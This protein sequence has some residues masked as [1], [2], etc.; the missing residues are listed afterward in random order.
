MAVVAN[1]PSQSPKDEKSMEFQ[2]LRKGLI[3][4]T[5]RVTS[6][7]GAAGVGSVFGMV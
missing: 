4:K 5:P 1:K 7:A 3:A 6:C 2:S